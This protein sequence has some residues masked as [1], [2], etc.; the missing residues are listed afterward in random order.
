MNLT[1]EQCFECCVAMVQVTIYQQMFLNQ[2][3]VAFGRAHLVSGNRFCSQIGMC[4]CVCVSTPE[5]IN[6]KSRETHAY[7]WIKQFMAF[8]FHYMT[9]AVDKLKGRGLSKT[10]RVMNAC[11]KR[12]R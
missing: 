9:L 3:H 11:Q 4:V 2:A 12:V 8:L 10:V 6:N 1:N 5:A 7:N